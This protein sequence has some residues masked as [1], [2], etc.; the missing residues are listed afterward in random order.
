MLR[1]LAC[2]PVDPFDR[3]DEQRLNDRLAHA[4]SSKRRH[5]LGRHRIPAQTDQDVDDFVLYRTLCR[6]DGETGAHQP[7]QTRTRR[8]PESNSSI[9]ANRMRSAA[10]VARFAA[11]AVRRTASRVSMIW[12]WTSC[13]GT[14][15]GI[16]LIW[17]L[18]I[19]A[20][21]VVFFAQSKQ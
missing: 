9:R 4:P 12:A 19:E 20:R 11:T 16:S 7:V 13:G 5:L 8:S 14:G 10:P 15:M 21:F 18:L 1:F 17:L 2:E 6:G 3:I